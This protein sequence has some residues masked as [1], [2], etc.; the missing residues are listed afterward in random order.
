M[1]VMDNDPFWHHGHLQL[2]SADSMAVGMS[3]AVKLIVNVLRIVSEPELG[4]GMESDA[5]ANASY[6]RYRL[7]HRF[8]LSR[9]DMVPDGAGGMRQI[10]DSEAL[11]AAVAATSPEFATETDGLQER[12][13]RDISYLAAMD[14]PTLLAMTDKI[15]DRFLSPETRR[16]E[17]LDP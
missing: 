15:I 13:D 1:D 8:E 17:T 16:R 11:A 9:H 3:P 12:I 14:S 6:R 5:G 2:M 7:I 4:T 10:T